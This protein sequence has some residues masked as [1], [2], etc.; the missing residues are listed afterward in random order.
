MLLHVPI[1]ALLIFGLPK[2]EP[3]PAEDESVKVELVPPPEEKKPEEKKPEEKPPEPKPPEQAKKQP[4]PPPPPPPDAA[5]P[6]PSTPMQSISHSVAE[7]ADKD[8]VPGQKEQTLPRQSEAPKPSIADMNPAKASVEPPQPEN[9]EVSKTMPAAN[10]VPQDIELPETQIAE[11]NPEKDEPDDAGLDEE[12]TTLEQAERRKESGPTA[13]STA[14]AKVKK[15]EELTEAKILYSE[16]ATS[17]PMIKN[18]I[19]N[20][21]RAARINA[22][23]QTELQQQLIHA[24]GYNPDLLPSFPRVTKGNV[25]NGV[26]GA[27]QSSGSWYDVTLICQVDNDARKVIS[28]RFDVGDKIPKSQWKSRGFLKY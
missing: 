15:S 22:L 14:E 6:E 4:P 21:P 16:K 1:V 24:G 8:T 11:V 13:S 12:K 27:F 19:K 20:L 9:S 17:D 3:K 28:F 7:F 5:K 26:G 18:A 2:I 23:C 10:S 25:L